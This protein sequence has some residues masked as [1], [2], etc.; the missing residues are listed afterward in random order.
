MP[1]GYASSAHKWL[2]NDDTYCRTRM[3]LDVYKFSD[4]P[5]KEAVQ[6]W[7]VVASRCY[8]LERCLLRFSGILDGPQDVMSTLLLGVLWLLMP[9]PIS[10]E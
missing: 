1:C 9:V 10:W 5:A 3:F 6:D 8:R 2:K 7:I 4:R